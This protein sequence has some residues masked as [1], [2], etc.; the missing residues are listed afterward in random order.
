MDLDQAREFLQEHHQ[1]VLV[2]RRK[3]GNVQTSPVVAGVDA[4][5]RVVVSSRETAYKVRNLRRDPHATFC[6]LPETFYGHW[7]QVDGTADVVSLPDAM[8]PLVDYY[9]AISGEHEDWDDYR[10]AMETERRVIVRVTIE[11][12]GP[13]RSG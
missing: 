10:R 2:T 8:E 6:V 13:T 12:V 4:Q 11:R 1:A 9:R 7:I 5:G 3:D